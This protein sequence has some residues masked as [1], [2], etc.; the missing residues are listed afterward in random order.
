MIMQALPRITSGFLLGSVLLVLPPVLANTEFRYCEPG[1]RCVEFVTCFIN[2]VKQPCAY[3]SGGATFGAVIFD[4]GYFDVEWLGDKL[5]RVTYG[6]RR[7]FRAAAK[8]SREGDYTVLRLS[9][10]V[11]VKYPSWDGRIKG[12]SNPKDGPL[13]THRPRVD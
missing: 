3:G 1:T 12:K 6:K 4:H 2:A 13:P 11:T 9:D 7:E 5:A 10:G 8:I